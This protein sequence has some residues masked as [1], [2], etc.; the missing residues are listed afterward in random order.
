MKGL[1]SILALAIGLAFT[2]PAFAGDVTAAKT[3]TDCAKAGGT[4]NATTKMCEETK[5]KP[6][7]ALATSRRGVG[8][9]RRPFCSI[10]QSWRSSAMAVAMMANYI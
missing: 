7:V 4:W 10:T 3:E 5:C 2:V 6:T 8:F 9:G 1:V